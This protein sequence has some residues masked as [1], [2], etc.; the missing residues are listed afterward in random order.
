M[1]VDGI[2]VCAEGVTTVEEVGRVVDLT[3]S[4]GLMAQLRLPCSE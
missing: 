2:Y 1:A 3:G 4:G